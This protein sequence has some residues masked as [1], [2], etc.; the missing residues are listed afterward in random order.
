[1]DASKMGT[2]PPAP[3]FTVKTMGKPHSKV[4]H[5]FP[6]WVGS[7]LPICGSAE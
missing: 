7:G 5:E 6:F 1:M 2:I 3:K 4:L